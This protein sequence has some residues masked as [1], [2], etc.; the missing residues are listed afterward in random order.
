MTGLTPGRQIVRLMRT[1]EPRCSSR[2][3]G[4]QPAEG[5]QRIDGLTAQE[6]L[7]VRSEGS[8]PSIEPGHA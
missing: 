1:V 5:V 3:K 4:R 8:V 6:M 2:A 7:G